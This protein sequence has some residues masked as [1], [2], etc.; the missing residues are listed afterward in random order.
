MS[1]VL[2][3]R[4][5]IKLESIGEI[6]AIKAGGVDITSK[7]MANSLAYKNQQLVALRDIVKA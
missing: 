6:L 4:K 1:S 2:N 5:K 7:K 3:R